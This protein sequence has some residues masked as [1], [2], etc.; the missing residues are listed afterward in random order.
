MANF[1]ELSRKDEK[2][3]GFIVDEMSRFAKFVPGDLK[4]HYEDHPEDRLLFIPHPERGSLPI[5]KAGHQR[6]WQIAER[7]LTA[8]GSEGKKYTISRVV[9]ALELEFVRRLRDCPDSITDVSAHDIFVFVS[10]EIQAKHEP[11]EHFVPCTVVAHTVPPKFAIGPVAFTLRKN[12]FE[13]NEPTLQLED[14]SRFNSLKEFFSQFMWVA[15]VTVPASDREIS[16][17]RARI[18]IQYALN[19]FKLF[20]GSSRASRVRQG[21]SLGGPGYSS[22]LTRGSQGFFIGWSRKMQDALVADDWHSYFS[23]SDAWKIAEGMIQLSLTDWNPLPELQ[24]RFL[25]ALTWHGEAISEPEPR[26]RLLKFWAAIERAVSTGTKVDVTKRAALLYSGQPEEF[27]NKFLLCQRL[28]SIRSSLIHGG[29][30]HNIDAIGLDALKTEHISRDVLVASLYLFQK[31]S[32]A[33]RSTR[34]GLEE[35]FSRLDS[36][37][38]DWR[39]KNGK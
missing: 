10:K 30:S 33:Q 19:L 4:K 28:Y 9:H 23:Q 31:L 24:Q 5:S 20:V 8:M 17:T 27:P 13:E 2:D 15:S 21:Y 3:Y 38:K 26:G 11:L 14:E 7:G 16:T 6:F 12:F 1:I 25:D 34:K 35:E 37:V 39:K 36:V 29:K 32:N 22:Q 18:V